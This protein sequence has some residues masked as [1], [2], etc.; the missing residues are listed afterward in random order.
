MLPKLQYHVEP[1]KGWLNDPNGLCYFNG[2]YHAF[3][4]HYPN[5]TVWTAPLY[6]AHD[7][8]DDQIHGEEQ[9][10]GLI[11]DPPYQSTGGCFSG[12]AFIKDGKAYFFY[13]AVGDGDVQTQ[14]LAT[15][16]DGITLKKY[17]GN[18][19][20]DERPVDPTGRDFRDPKVFE[21]TDGTYRMVCGTG[22]EGYAAV[23]LYKSSDLYN[24][25]YVGPIFETREMGPVL[26]CPTCIPWRTSGCCASPVWTSPRPFSMW[27]APLTA[28]TSPQ[29]A[30]RS[31]KS[32]PTTT[33]PRALRMRRAGALSWHG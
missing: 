15:S 30:C 12:S 6:W 26:E 27:W 28:N 32:A 31:R 29:R 4:Q 21:W 25:E 22:H 14:C 23:L 33:L 1:E 5:A 7:T 20:I 3:F 18:P 24:W 19:I 11:P 10:I 13:T 2:K 16:E 8:S 9:P 17:E